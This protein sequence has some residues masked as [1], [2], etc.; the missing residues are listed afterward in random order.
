MWGLSSLFLA[1]WQF[2]VTLSLLAV[3]ASGAFASLWILFVCKYQWKRTGKEAWNGV[4]RFWVRFFALLLTLCFSVSIPLLIQVGTVWPTLLM[5]VVGVVGPLLS[6]AVLLAFVTKL[7]FLNIM[8]YQQSRVANWV[9]NASILSASLGFSGVL[10]LILVIVAWMSDPQGSISLNGIT[11]VTAWSALLSHAQIPWRWGAFIVGAFTVQGFLMMGIS[12]W[13]THIRPLNQVENLSFKVGAGSALA[14]LIGA[15]I[16]YIYKQ[17]SHADQLGFFA[18][19]EH[20]LV[21]VLKYLVVCQVILILWASLWSFK[22]KRSAARMPRWLLRSYSYFTF[23]PSIGLFAG[24]VIA[25]QYGLPALVGE[26]ILIS[27][28][29]RDPGFWPLAFST[30][31]YLALFIALLFGFINMLYYAARFGVVPVR[32]I[33]RTA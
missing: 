28:V 7:V 16:L 9:H 24:F 3:L 13:Q 30:L 5:K 23:L 20:W 6:L 29:F 8:L 25:A 32:K 11:Q 14:G 4:Y 15:A 10:Y 33:R 18:F 17:I 21:T 26:T 27:E 31:A 22:L 19:P 2:F 12:A 1:T